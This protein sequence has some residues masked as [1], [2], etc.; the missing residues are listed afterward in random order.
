MVRDHVGVHFFGIQ[1]QFW[2]S[3]LLVIVTGPSRVQL[4]S[5]R[6]GIFKIGPTRIERPN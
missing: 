1:L 2:N 4:I 3:D 5:I 6:A